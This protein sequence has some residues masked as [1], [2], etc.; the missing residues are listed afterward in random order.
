MHI[1]FWWENQRKRDHYEDLDVDGRMILR[2]IL[3]RLDGMIWT[4]LICLR[5]GPSG[6]LL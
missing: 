3:E 2:W 5:I 4:G 1:E 6:E